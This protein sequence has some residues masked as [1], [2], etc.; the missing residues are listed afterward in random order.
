M[1]KNIDIRE[2]MKT[3]RDDSYDVH[4]TVEIVTQKT[5]RRRGIYIP[6]LRAVINSFSILQHCPQQCHIVRAFR[7]WVSQTITETIY[8]KNESTPHRNEQHPRRRNPDLHLRRPPPIGPG[9]PSHTRLPSERKKEK[10][11]N[12]YRSSSGPKLGT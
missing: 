3:G 9:P 6:Q 8:A 4:F 5:H 12:T 2:H 7:A 11:M 10:S 1:T